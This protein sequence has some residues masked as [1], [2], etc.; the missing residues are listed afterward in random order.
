VNNNYIDIINVPVRKYAKVILVNTE[1]STT[2]TNMYLSVGEQQLRYA[3]DE[4]A[5]YL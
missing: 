3:N 1:P 4:G 5:R 2:E